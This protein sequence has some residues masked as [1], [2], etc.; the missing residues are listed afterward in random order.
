M[1]TRARK[2]DNDAGAPGAEFSWNDVVGEWTT[3]GQTL[4]ARLQALQQ[5]SA[6]AV[7]DDA[8][9]PPVDQYD[10][11]VE[12]YI[13]DVRAIWEGARSG[14]AVVGA[15]H[16][17]AERGGAAADFV[18]RLV[19]DPATPPAT[20]LFVGFPGDPSEPEHARFYVDPALSAFVEVPISFVLHT[21]DLPASQ[22]PLGG[23]FV[24]LR[25][26]E[27]VLDQLQHALADAARVQQQIWTAGANGNGAEEVPLSPFPDLAVAE[28][29]SSATA[30]TDP[31][32]DDDDDVPLPPGWPTAASD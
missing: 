30:P 8:T 1:N 20:V 25:R 32:D 26:E 18:E 4:L 16:A 22:A 13:A 24:W 14:T 23:Q 12:A 5:L 31:F 15:A 11:A 6:L 19:D 7:F 27:D 3:A 21:R 29:V 28:P 17:S 9:R 10:D 2:D